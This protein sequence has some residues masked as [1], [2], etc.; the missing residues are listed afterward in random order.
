MFFVCSSYVLREVRAYR[1]KLTHVDSLSVLR[2][3]EQ[4]SGRIYGSPSLVVE[5]V[6]RRRMS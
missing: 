5:D 1:D 4:G 3:F 2:W 6:E